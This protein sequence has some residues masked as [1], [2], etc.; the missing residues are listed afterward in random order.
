[1]VPTVGPAV[2]RSSGS[3]GH[4]RSPG[5]SNSGETTDWT[6]RMVLPSSEGSRVTSVFQESRIGN[7]MIKGKFLCTGSPR[8]SESVV[9]KKVIGPFHK[10]YTKRLR[11]SSITECLS[12]IVSIPSRT[13]VNEGCG[14]QGYRRGPEIVVR[15]GPLG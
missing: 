8:P 9:I 10:I 4:W 13:E 1:M 11:I 5:R 14:T 12:F 6:R 2:G 3:L 15:S 7:I